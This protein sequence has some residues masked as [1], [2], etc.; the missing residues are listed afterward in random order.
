[1]REPRRALALAAALAPALAAALAACGPSQA[2]VGYRA[3]TESFV[4]RVSSTPMPPFAREKT[5]FKVVVRDRKS[6]QP[7]E[8]GEGRIFAQN[9]DGKREWD[10]LLAG[11]EVGTYYGTLSFL[12][13]GEWAMAI[14]FRRDS[15]KQ[16]ERIDWTQQ[17]LAEREGTP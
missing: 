7:I 6:D 13:A 17:V 10:V 14:Q 12:T 8:N 2:P 16:L 4:V 9:Q 11:P 5:Q 15:T 3:R 1:V